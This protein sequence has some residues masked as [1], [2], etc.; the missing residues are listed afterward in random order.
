MTS[1]SVDIK[2]GSHRNSIMCHNEKAVI[3]VAILT[4]QE[5]DATT[6]DHTTVTFEGASEIHVRKG[7]GEPVRHEHDVDGDGD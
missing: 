5:F 7:S 4:D 2:P 6:V 3:E 1:V